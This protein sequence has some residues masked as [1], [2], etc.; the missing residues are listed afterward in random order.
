MEIGTEKP[1]IV[2]EPIESPVPG[3]ENPAMPEPEIETET[4]E[5]EEEELIPA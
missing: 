1:A 4:V 5:V 2:I 3:V